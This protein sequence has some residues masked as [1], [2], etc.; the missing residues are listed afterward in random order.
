MS[1]PARILV[2]DDEA[3]ICQSLKEMLTQEGYDVTAVQS[4][5]EAVACLAGRKFGLAL[6]DLRLGDMDGMD[7]VAALRRET[8][9]TVII[10]LTAHAS[11]ETAV[12]SLR[13]GVHDYLFKPCRPADLRDSVRRGLLKRREEQEHQVLLAHLENTLVQSLNSLRASLG[14]QAAPAPAQAAP[15]TRAGLAVDLVQRTVELDGRPLELSKTEF[16]LLAYLV[17]QA[18]RVVPAQELVRQV[19]GYDTRP[20]E[21]RELM[22]YHVYRIRQKAQAVD[23]CADPIQTIRGVGYKIKN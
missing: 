8:P 15:A 4:G 2:V 10:I 23:R 1:E 21:A 18:P 19:E 13:H 22:R 11:L 16:D 17:A 20:E 3:E 7:V 9:D 12:E 6:I 5:G 14:P